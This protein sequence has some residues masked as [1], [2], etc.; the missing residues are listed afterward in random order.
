MAGEWRVPMLG[1]QTPLSLPF[2]QAHCPLLYVKDFQRLCV[3]VGVGVSQ[4]DLVGVDEV[5]VE[6]AE[7]KGRKGGK[8]S[9]QCD[10][11]TRPFSPS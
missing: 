9:Q 10:Q 2:A 11:L 7:E 5:G 6:E 4:L 3:G 8:M 1:S